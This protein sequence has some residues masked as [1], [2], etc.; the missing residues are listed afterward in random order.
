[1]KKIFLPLVLMLGLGLSNVSA[2]EG[3]YLTV[4]GA[5]ALPFASV[6]GYANQTVEANDSIFGGQTGAV[7]FV[8]STTTTALDGDGFPIISGGNSK[9]G[10]NVGKGLNF[11]VAFGYMFDDHFG[12]E[13]GVGYLLG[14]KTEFLQEYINEMDPDDIITTSMSGEVSA[15]QIRVNPSFVVSSDY[16]DFMPY[17]KFGVVIGFGTKITEF[18]DDK[19]M[20]GTDNIT[21]TY[22][23]TGGVS[24]GLSGSLGALY[25]FNKKTGIFLELSLISMGYSPTKRVITQYSINGEDMLATGDFPLS[26]LETEY[27]DEVDFGDNGDKTNTTLALKGKYPMSSFNINLGVRFSF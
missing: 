16:K 2:Q 13:L 20:N 25:N 26:S 22:E 23:S 11:G 17:A 27:V 24:L 6:N 21:Q 9:I 19:K 3:A 8:N 4:Y 18:Y 1:M 14:S 12:F 7:S 5:Y 15:N 10:I